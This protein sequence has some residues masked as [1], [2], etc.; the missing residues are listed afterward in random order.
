MIIFLFLRFFLR[1]IYLYPMGRLKKYQTEEERI[2]KQLEY[3]KKY[4]W[5]NKKQID[6][7]SKQRYYRNL[8]NNKS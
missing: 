4:Y 7:N 8:Q 6:E 1:S 5:K 3:S 2:L